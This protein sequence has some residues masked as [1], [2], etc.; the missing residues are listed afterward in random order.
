MDLLKKYNLII[1]RDNWLNN[2]KSDDNNSD[3]NSSNNTAFIKQ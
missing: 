3:N 1:A 2:N